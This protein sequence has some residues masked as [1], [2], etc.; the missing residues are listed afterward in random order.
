MRD[1][2]CKR[3]RKE[4]RK[5]YSF[6]DNENGIDDDGGSAGGANNIEGNV[7]WGMNP[8]HL[9]VT[10]PAYQYGFRR[11]L[12]VFSPGHVICKKWQ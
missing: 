5:V 10:G 11:I 7:E 1:R 8:Y 2:D 9:L 3:A 4:K 12:P 6:G